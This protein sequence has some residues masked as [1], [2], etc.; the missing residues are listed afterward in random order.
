MQLGSVITQSGHPVVFYSR[1]L[2]PSQMH[3]TT[4]EQELLLNVET[5]KDFWPMLLGQKLICTTQ[6]LTK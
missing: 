2:N 5:L 3:Y 1:K 4:G 6:G